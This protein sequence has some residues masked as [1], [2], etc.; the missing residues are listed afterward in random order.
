[1]AIDK[2]AGTICTYSVQPVSDCS[3]PGMA[4]VP[5][6]KNT[7]SKTASHTNSAEDT[8]GESLR[9]NRW[10]RTA[11]RNTPKKKMPKALARVPT[12]PNSPCPAATASTIVLPLMGPTNSRNSCVKAMASTYPPSIAKTIVT[13]MDAWSLS[14]RNQ[15][16]SRL[17]GGAA[18]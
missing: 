17:A 15:I 7:S 2:M 3:A 11:P 10:R 16:F 18:M 8:C 6:A 5:M 1:M 13:K 4:N 9:L 14:A 12:T